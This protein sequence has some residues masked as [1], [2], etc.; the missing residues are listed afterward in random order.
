MDDFD[1]YCQG[2]TGSG[3]EFDWNMLK[4]DL[5][6]PKNVLKPWVSSF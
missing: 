6:G 1:L 3:Q 2:H 4:I 5:F